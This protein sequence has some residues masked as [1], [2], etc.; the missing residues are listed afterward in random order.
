MG[1]AFTSGGGTLLQAKFYL[2][3]SGSPTGNAV[4]K[5]YAITGTYGTDSKPTGAALATSDNFD[6][7]TLTASLQLITL[8]FSGVNQISLTASTKYFVTFEFTT[9][10]SVNVGLDASSPSHGGNYAFEQAGVWTGLSTKDIIFYVYVPGVTT[11]LQPQYLLAPTKL[12]NNTSLQNY[13]TSWASGEWSTTNAYVFQAEAANGDTSVIELD[14]SGGT[15]VQNSPISTIDNRATST[16]MC[17]SALS[18]GNLDVKATTNS[19]AIYA[20]RI[21]VDVGS[22]QTAIC[23]SAAANPTG[24]VNKFWIR[25]GPA[26]AIIR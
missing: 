2:S 21:L 26:Q 16:P 3:K 19:G 12:A 10:D 22:T 9:T 20:A 1:Q 6:V 17:F 11:L 18:T 14:T 25:S 4:A 13:L 5:I 15:Q 8:T 24:T 7:S 23:A